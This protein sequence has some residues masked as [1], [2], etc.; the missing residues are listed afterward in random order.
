MRPLRPLRL[1][2][3]R[4]LRVTTPSRTA[5]IADRLANDEALMALARLVRDQVPALQ[6]KTDG[7]LIDLIKAQ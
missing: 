4:P 6:G 1:R 7:E 2:W 5:R 3:L